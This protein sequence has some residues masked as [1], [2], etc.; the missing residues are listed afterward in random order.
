MNVTPFKAY[1]FYCLDEDGHIS[2]R[3]TWQ[4]I[5]L[6][7]KTISLVSSLLVLL[8]YIY[9][10]IHTYIHTINARIVDYVNVT[11]VYFHII[12]NSSFTIS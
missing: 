5:T 10:Y 3:S 7:R 8:L 4:V 6:Y 9:I 2:G 12:Y 11:F 1:P